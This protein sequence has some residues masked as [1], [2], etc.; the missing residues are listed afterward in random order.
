MTGLIIVILII[1]VIIYVLYTV[2]L[3]PP[4]PV[5]PPISDY[6]IVSPN[7]MF[8]QYSS[9]EWTFVP[10]G[11]AD[12]VTFKNSYLIDAK[13]GREIAAETKAG[14]SNVAIGTVPKNFSKVMYKNNK[15]IYENPSWALAGN[16][17][18]RPYSYGSGAPDNTWGLHPILN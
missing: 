1:V 11:S 4:S 2:P 13:T 15:L 18:P 16:T 17:H 10:Q 5:P 3:I 14:S 8:L 12:V 6:Y 7:G 9:G